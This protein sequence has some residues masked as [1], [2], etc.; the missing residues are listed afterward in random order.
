MKK[1]TRSTTNRRIFGICG[2]FAEWMDVDPTIIRIV[3]ITTAILCPLSILVYL[4]T[5][6]I[7]PQ[8]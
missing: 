8:E 2:G 6:I 4:L 5:G 3:A 7:M 1:L